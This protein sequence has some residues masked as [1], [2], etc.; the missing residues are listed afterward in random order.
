MPIHLHCEDCPLRATE[1]QTLWKITRQNRKFPDAEVNIKC[2][3]ED[4]VRTLNAQYR[5][6]NKATNILTFSYSDE[7]D[8]ALC[9][10]VADRE[11]KE[12]GARRRDYIALLFVHAFLHVTG[13][14][15]EESPQEA[16]DT[17]AAEHAILREAGFTP[18]SL[19]PDGE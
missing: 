13:M 3:S 7:H 10:P 9:I 12:R 5:K 4:E 2:V 17:A 6:K 8:I 16:L 14:D 1:I 18:V 19:S 11:A 15:H